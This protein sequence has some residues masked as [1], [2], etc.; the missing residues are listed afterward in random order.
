MTVTYFMPILHGHF[1][2]PWRMDIRRML[3]FIQYCGAVAPL[4]KMSSYRHQG[5]P[6]ADNVLAAAGEGVP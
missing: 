5:H 2:V 1:C 4:L 3:A 6:C